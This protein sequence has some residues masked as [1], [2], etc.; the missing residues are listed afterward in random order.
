FLEEVA[1][2]I[3]KEYEGQTER[4]TV[5]FPNRRAGVFFQDL[6]ARKIRQQGWAPQVLT[7]EELA[8]HLSELVL[9]DRLTLIY[10]LYEVFREHAS[11]GETFDRFYF[12]GDLLLQDFN[13][14]DMALVDAGD[15]FTNLRDLK[16]LEDNYAYLSDEQ[17][18]TIARFWRS[19][20]AHSDQESSPSQKQFLSLWNKLLPVYRHF[21]DKLLEQGLAYEGLMY[22]TLAEKMSQGF[23]YEGGP[24]VIAGMNALKQAEERI[25]RHLV[26]ECHARLFWDIDRYYLDEP[27][28]E[29]G[30]FFRKYRQDAIF[31]SSFPEK[32]PDHFHTGEKREIH[33][34]GVSLEVGQAKKLGEYLR[35]IAAQ[36]GFRPEKVAV[37]LPDEHLLFPVLHSLPAE[38]RRVNVT[39]GY[40]LRNTSLYSFVEHLLNLQLEKK[41][42]GEKYKYHHQGL[43]ALLRHPYVR[44]E[45]AASAEE[46]IRRIEAQ[47]A[48]M[49]DPAR[50]SGD[51]LFFQTLLR[52][53]EQVPDLFDYLREVSSLV[54]RLMHEAGE[55][56]EENGEMSIPMLE[57]ELLYHFYLQ[58]NRL[59]ALTRE[60]QFDFQLPAFIRLLRQIL[61]G[62]RVPFTG[63]PL[64]G[65]QIM[66]LLESRNLDFEYVFVLSANEGI[67][68][69]GQTQNS[70]IP[71]NLKKGFGLFTGEMQDAFYAHAFFRLLHCARKVYLFHNTEDLQHLSGEMSRFLYQLRYEAF[72]DD[73]KQLCFPDQEGDFSLKQEVLQAQVAALAPQPIGIQ[74]SPEVM[75]QLQRFLQGSRHHALTPSAINTYLDCRLKFYYQYVVRLRETDEVQEEVDAQVFGNILHKAMEMIYQRLLAHKKCSR[76][77]AEDCRQLRNAQW[78]E[79]AVNDAFLHHFDHDKADSFRFEGRNIIAR[80]IVQK[81]ASRILEYDEAYAPF[82]IVS[83]EK[84]GEEGYFMQMQI[85]VEGKKQAVSLK[86]IIDR[87]DR[88]D[89]LLR[90]LDYKTGRDE[91]RAV[92]IASLFDRDHPR[93]NKAA[94]QALFYALLYE[95]STADQEAAI[96]PGLINASDLFSDGFTPYLQLG[97]D[98]VTDFAAYREEFTA[99]LGSLLH[100]IFNASVAFDQTEDEKKCSYCPYANICY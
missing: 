90:V 61:Q 74:K 14:V 70:F 3:I 28:Q 53:V 25:I 12:W 84:A 82:D 7:F 55:E 19:F 29:A 60:R 100:E 83:L 24:L 8:V 17:K 43:L 66:G 32:V 51:R 42:G 86:G 21:R 76:V 27:V 11:T 40:P 23:L 68:P 97:R 87:V 4:L 47:N 89:E 37:V 75:Q 1:E 9:A 48:V 94:M 62:L 78:L 65:L 54:H 15:I 93:R 58:I 20:Q 98:T 33:I 99:A 44:N 63:E 56:E 46:N 30:M 36:P 41:T 50:L 77:E 45:T 34:N 91:R 92:D 81:M 35:E 2:Q 72:Q 49:V 96:A 5:V 85:S 88:K 79:K 57:R 71:Q 80:E 39:M 26:K 6:L 22:R 38:I 16:A 31:K 10:Q 67:L 64:R 59:R 18:E 95:S 69:P 13:E 52:P 73:K